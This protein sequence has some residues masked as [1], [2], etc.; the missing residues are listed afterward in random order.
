[1]AQQSGPQNSLLVI[2]YL[3]LRKAIGILGVSLPFVLALG[4]ILLGAWNTE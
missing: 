3:K 4:H 2:S 1:M